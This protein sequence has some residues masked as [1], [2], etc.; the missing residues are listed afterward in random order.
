MV[1]GQAVLIITW[2]HP[3]GELQS[4]THRRAGQLWDS[5]LG[6]F[7]S[8]WRFPY[9]MNF[10]S[11]T[12][13]S[14]V[15]T[16]WTGPRLL[17]STWNYSVLLCGLCGQSLFFYEL[18]CTLVYFFVLLLSVIVL[19]VLPRKNVPEENHRT[20]A[21]HW[22]TLSHNGVSVQLAWVEFELTILVVIG[23][24]CIRICKSKYHTITTTTAPYSS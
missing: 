7:T 17:E 20:A 4:A 5:F 23:T 10:V 18:F 1:H 11:F 9:Q 19:A 21:S 2:Q 22:H 13:N 16:S 8:T 24:N 3:P 6:T 12:S 14:I 15:E